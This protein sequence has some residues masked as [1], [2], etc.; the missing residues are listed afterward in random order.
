[1]V[2]KWL[3][4]GNLTLS[5]VISTCSTTKGRLHSRV[6]VGRE[7]EPGRYD[8]W[9]SGQ[10]QRYQ[11][12]HT[13]YHISSS[14]Y[15]I[16]IY[17]VII[18]IKTPYFRDNCFYM[19][20]H[21]VYMRTEAHGHRHGFPNWKPRSG[22]K[23]SHR[24]KAHPCGLP[25]RPSKHK[26]TPLSPGFASNLD[27]EGLQLYMKHHEEFPAF[28]QSGIAKNDHQPSLLTLA[29]DVFCH[30]CSFGE[31]KSYLCS[32]AVTH[33]TQLGPIIGLWIFGT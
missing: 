12:Y 5:C 21:C 19:H 29:P 2:K 25:M 26:N 11:Q 9:T 14:M 18:W 15:H 30:F 33:E 7:P 22:R 16:Y 23:S 13:I 28:F 1:M 20:T 6:P 8:I 32:A 17:I 24:A 31:F 27:F 3:H 10:W 4:S